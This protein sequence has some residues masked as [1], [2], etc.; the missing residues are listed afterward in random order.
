MKKV[1][2]V[3]FFNSTN[4]GDQAI[5][6]ALACILSPFSDVKRL[7]ISGRHVAEN[8]DNA[9]PKYI[10]VQTKCKFYNIKS[11]LSLR[12]PGRLRFAKS[13]IDSCDVIL[14]AGGNMIMDLERFSC[15]S[16]LCNRYVTYAKKRG[17]KVIFAFVG[18]GKTKTPMQRYYWKK[19]I[20]RSDFISVRDTLSRDVLL[21]KLHCNRQIAVWKD[22]AFLLE[23][24][25]KQVTNQR[26][27]INIYLD[28]VDSD[29]EK[30]KLKGAYIYFIEQIKTKYSVLL[31]VT[32]RNDSS[33]LRQVYDS[34][35][36]TVGVE[37]SFPYNWRELVEM[38]K[39]V[40]IA[41]T[42]R[43]HA[44]IIATTQSIP[45]IMFSWDKKIDGVA[46]D[47]GLTNVV[48]DINSV[49][50]K[51]EALLKIIYTMMDDCLQLTKKT[52]E[53][54]CKIKSDFIDYTKQL[55]ELIGG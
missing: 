2:I 38:Y 20:T 1:L 5:G 42:T 51:K 25:K 9:A 40:D 53:I 13:C 47:I 46:K 36:D 35:S 39:T 32:E 26:I 16:F 34:L 11:F 19:A 14:I 21:N 33:G 8:V 49:Y 4:L 7:D 17:K 15:Y 10:T 31:Y 44:F 55:N 48:F 54:G 41:I 52:A 28:S 50:D 12:K 18:V 22:P 29:I 45:T 30:E 6:E 43:M 23:N 3:S 27:A 37:M 24:K